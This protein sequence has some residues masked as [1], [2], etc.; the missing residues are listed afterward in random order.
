MSVFFIKIGFISIGAE[1]DI[2]HPVRGSAHLLT[3]YFQV[4]DGI[5][6]DDQFVVDVTDYKAMPERFH[7]VAEDV[8][9]EAMG[10]GLHGIGQDITAYSLDDV[11]HEFWTV[12]FDA[13]PSFICA[14]TFIGDGFTTEL[15]HTYTRL[16]V[17]QASS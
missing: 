9:A 1:Q 3:D 17:R 4:N 12:G 2:W 13:F 16:Y 7:S 14:D 11:L 10:K 15:V 5:A 8:T 6:F